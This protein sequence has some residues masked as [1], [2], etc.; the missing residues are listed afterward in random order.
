PRTVERQ[1]GPSTVSF[2]YPVITAAPT[3]ALQ[4]ALTQEMA[5]FLAPPT[6]GARQAGTP[7]AAAD[8]FLVGY[9]PSDSSP[10]MLSRKAEIVYQDPRVVSL[11]LSEEI[12]AGGPHGG[13]TAHYASFDPGT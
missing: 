10:W 12:A 4:V 9:S 7:E 13:S 8:E 6:G 11:R 2:A 1:K 5:N 3:E